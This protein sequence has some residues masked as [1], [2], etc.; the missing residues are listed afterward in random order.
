MEEFLRD[1]GRRN[2]VTGVQRVKNPCILEFSKVC[3][4]KSSR[5]LRRVNPY[6]CTE[7]FEL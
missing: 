2:N 4:V 1:K 7:S 5:M 3:A 6:K